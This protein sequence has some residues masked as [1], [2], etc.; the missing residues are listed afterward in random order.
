MSKRYRIVAETYGGKTEYLVQRK[1]IFGFWYNP[2][3]IDANTIGLYSN[4][5]DARTYIRNKQKGTT[6]EIIEIPNNL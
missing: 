4:F 1:S 5:D 6:I 2:Y 3:N